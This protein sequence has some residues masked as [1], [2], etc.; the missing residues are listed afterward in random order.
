MNKTYNGMVKSFPEPVVGALI[1]NNSGEI[2][3][4]Q[5]H[6]WKDR[7]VIPGGHVEIGESLEDAVRREIKEETGLD[8]YDIKFICYNECINDD[9]F[10]KKRHFIFM[11]FA[12]RTKSED[13][14]LNEEGQR[15][16]WVSL[17]EAEKLPLGKFTKNLIETY[18]RKN[19]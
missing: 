11:D 13:V 15:H 2:L 18:K 9:A 6:K 12:C 3:L 5:S 4:I 16:V 19:L 7:Y 1:F 17:D 8:V 14:T 10:W